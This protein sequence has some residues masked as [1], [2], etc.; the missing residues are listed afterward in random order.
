MPAEPDGPI[1][2]VHDDSFI[3]A[4]SNTNHFVFGKR[5]DPFCL[6]H[7]LNLEMVQSKVLT[8]EPLNPFDLWVAVQICAT[9][10]TP[11]HQAPNIKA[12][13]TLRFLWE[14]GRFKF[15]AEV[16]RFSVY[17]QDY[18]TG[19]KFWPNQHEAKREGDGDR[20]IDETLELALHLIK[21]GHFTQRE[22]WTMPT[23]MARWCSAG[24]SKLAGNKVDIW[25]PEHQRLFEE[26]KIKRE[27]KIDIRGREIAHEQNIPYPE[28]RAKA[29]TEHW[30]KVEEA[31]FKI[32]G[33]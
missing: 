17:L 29:N 23:G 22:A 2:F 24:L 14:V 27:A 19:P 11:S 18:T 7:Q 4:F 12:P 6:W 10:W 3:E 13:G 9:R 8:S 31:R 25:T 21:E 16:R 15:P 28:A 5:L 20:D 1:R 32:P 30:A 33:R 26:H